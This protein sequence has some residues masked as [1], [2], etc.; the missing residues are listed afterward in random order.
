MT[1]G[2]E[3]NLQLQTDGR[4]Q[5]VCRAASLSFWVGSLKCS[6]LLG[7]ARADRP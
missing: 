4:R 7:E 2:K 1:V 5:T 3:T 6:T